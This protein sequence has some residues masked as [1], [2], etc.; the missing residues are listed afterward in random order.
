MPGLYIH[1]PFC[2]SACPY[3]DF[4]FV[5]GRDRQS[6]RYVDALIAEFETRA[7][8]ST[9]PFDT[10][11]F[12][13]GTPTSLAASDL[14]RILETVET[15][16]RL[17]DTAEITVE[18][19]PNDRE[20]FESLQQLGITR[21]S[22]GIQSSDDATLAA[23]GRTHS[24]QDS[25]DAVRTAREAG[26]D[27]VSLDAIFGAPGQSV[28]EWEHDLNTLMDLNPDHVSLYG[29]TIEPQTPFGKQHASDRL[30]VPDDDEQSRM[31]DVAL[32]CTDRA[33]Y[34]QYE[35]SNFA[36]PGYES[37]HNLACWRGDTYL[38]IGMGAHS[39]DGSSRSWN[40]RSLNTYLD[41][42]QASGS[43]EE[44]HE[45]LPKE[46]RDIEHIMLGLRT[47]DGIESTLIAE[48]AT[49]TRLLKEQLIEQSGTRLRLTR[50]GKPIAD[51][52]C[53][54]LVKDL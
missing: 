13:G 20:K 41:R 53:A 31:Y 29:L 11:Y 46:A 12:G 42:V 18:A 14:A 49:T 39:Y 21:L 33:G 52:V 35:I 6:S 32:E 44:E 26:F 1:I 17:S 30:I 8:A 10:V 4:A 2:A 15:K 7:S 25:A 27:N 47:R 37:A 24:G 3:C 54:E 23:L 19:N 38:G 50:R 48:G 5:V 45:R 22:L 34:E 43:A 51:L 40:T 28:S 36:R 9:H 16:G